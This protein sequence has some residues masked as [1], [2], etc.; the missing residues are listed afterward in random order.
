[1]AY[2]QDYRKMIL[3]KLNS[4]YSYRELAAEYGISRSTIQLWK[5][6]I[7]RKPYPKRT[8]KI[9]DEL[10]RK[11]VEQFPDDFKENELFALTVHKE[12]L[13]W[14]LNG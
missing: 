13:V 6:C 7:E 3:E 8:N 12:P 1:M 14:H 2:S 4:G 9:N 5:K 10:L 11:D